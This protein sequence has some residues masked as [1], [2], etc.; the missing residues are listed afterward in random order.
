MS[1]DSPDDL[2]P[3]DAEI[4]EFIAEW[5]A[6]DRHAAEVL[7]HALAGQRGEAPP[8]AGLEEIAAR[9]RQGLAARDYPFDW[10]GRAA[11]LAS[12]PPR[13]GTVELLLRCAAATISPREETGLDVEEEAILLSL[14]HADWLGAIVSAVR[15]GPGG[16]ASP[17]ALA[18][19]IAACPEVESEA[20]LDLE[21]ETAHA[22]AAFW[23]LAAP[24]HALGLVD[25]DQRLTAWGAWVLPR[26]L[27]QAWGS[28][29]DAD[30]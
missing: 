15:V 22:E 7:R 20:G 26:A 6:V 29:F 16:D 5:E 1:A 27:A 3:S 25:G 14:Q 11:G 30:S 17:R 21:E 2:F 13:D 12:G 28:E 8:A 23:I 9:L 24:W 10:I 19:G 4:D 18:A